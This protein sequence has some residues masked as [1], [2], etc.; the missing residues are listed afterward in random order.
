MHILSTPLSDL[1]IR[2]L[3]RSWLK[4]HAEP[5]GRTLVVE[6]LYLTQVPATHG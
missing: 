3:P 1:W 2:F 4:A 6:A 5:I